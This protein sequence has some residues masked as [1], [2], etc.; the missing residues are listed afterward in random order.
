[1][2]QMGAE[3]F[4][5][6]SRTRS[7]PGLASYVLMEYPCA[8]LRLAGAPIHSELDRASYRITIGWVDFAGD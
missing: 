2:R 6:V 8:D 1:M 4:S 5:L 7:Q 3:S